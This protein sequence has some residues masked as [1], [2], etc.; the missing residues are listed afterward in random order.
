MA[1]SASSLKVHMRTHRSK[2]I[3]ACQHEGCGY[4]TF[5]ANNLIRHNKTH[6]GK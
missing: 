2:E 5:R 4:S 3:F 6:M 1:S